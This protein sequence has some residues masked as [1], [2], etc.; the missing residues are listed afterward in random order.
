VLSNNGFNA[1]EITSKVISWI[2]QLNMI[3]KNPKSVFPTLFEF[4]IKYKI[5]NLEIRIKN[6]C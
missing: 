2:T 4:G 1:T 6:F 3:I 5:T